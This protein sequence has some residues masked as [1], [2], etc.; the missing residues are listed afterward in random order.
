MTALDRLFSYFPLLLTLAAASALGV[1]AAWPSGWTVF[2]FVAVLYL[3][4]PIVL[5]ILLRWTPIKPGVTRIDG[6]AF[7]PWL[8]THHIQV[9]YDAL[10]YLEALLRVIPG[11]YSMWLRLWGSRVGYGVEWSVNTSI[12]DRH[13]M[14]IGN[15]VVFSR[16]V[17]L[18]AHARKKTE[19]G[20]LVLVRPV[21]IGSYAFLGAC[22][23]VGPGASV[24]ANSSVPALAVVDVNAIFGEG[25]RHPAPEEAQFELVI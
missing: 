2:L 7:S 21:R 6:R 4:P 22:A 13:L 25:E 15:R 11:F 9:F 8:A 20:L 18:S 17:D 1:L 12:L 10:P 3:L 5:R 16:Q 23:R 24:P 14:D 19:G